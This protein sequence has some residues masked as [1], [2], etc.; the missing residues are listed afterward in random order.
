M[1][2]VAEAG[3][4]TSDWPNFR[5]GLRKARSNPKYCYEW[6]FVEPNTVVVL[7]LW[8]RDMQED[9]AEPVNEN[10]TIVEGVY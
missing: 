4:D 5:G 1:D 8:F 3:I 9:R 7:N 2:L 10:E 6:S